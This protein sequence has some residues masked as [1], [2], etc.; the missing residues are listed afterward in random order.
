MSAFSDVE[1]HIEKSNGYVNDL[2]SRVLDP[3]EEVSF[4]MISE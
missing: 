3:S 4:G 2:P 1:A